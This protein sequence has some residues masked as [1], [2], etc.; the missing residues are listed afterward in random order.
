MKS[1]YDPWNDVD[2]CLYPK[3]YIEGPVYTITDSE[4]GEIFTFN[5]TK[6][7]AEKLRVGGTAFVK[8]MPKEDDLIG[9]V[10]YVLDADTV[11]ANGDLATI[12]IQAVEVEGAGKVE[13]EEKEMLKRWRCPVPGCEYRRTRFI[14][15][16]AQHVQKQHPGVLSDKGEAK[17]LSDTYKP[18]VEVITIY[19]MARGRIDEG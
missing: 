15:L 3:A 13:K 1:P 16:W 14:N 19:L 7:F 4:T 18:E 17:T 12:I 9:M 11:F 6:A 8:E 10:I 5:C 2:P